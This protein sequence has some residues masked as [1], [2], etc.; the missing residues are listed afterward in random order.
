MLLGIFDEGV[1]PSWAILL[2]VLAII[3][4][5]VLYYNKAKTDQIKRAEKEK[6]AY[7]H[8]VNDSNYNID[9]SGMDGHRDEGLNKA[10]A[11]RAVETLKETNEVPTQEEFNEINKDLNK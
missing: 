2:I 9:R 6:D 1:L 4:G 11:Q 8:V 10:E 5:L 3:A 7:S